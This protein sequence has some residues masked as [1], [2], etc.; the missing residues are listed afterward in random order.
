[1]NYNM[2]EWMK[3]VQAIQDKWK[4]FSHIYDN[5]V[6]SNLRFLDS[7]IGDSLAKFQNQL[8]VFKRMDLS[9]KFEVPLSENLELFKDIDFEQIDKNYKENYYH[10]LC[11]L[12]ELEQ[13][14]Y[15]HSRSLKEGL[16]FDANDVLSEQYISTITQALEIH[17]ADTSLI[18]IWRGA[19]MAINS[20]NP[21]KIRHCFVSL[22]TLLEYL[23]NKKLNIT[24]EDVQNFVDPSFDLSKNP[25]GKLKLAAFLTKE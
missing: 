16:T 3:A 1:M 17:L 22:R 8:A 19:L 9:Y 7:S 11:L 12:C 4:P 5:P 2:P 25:G 15:A 18:N 21:D 14:N 6:I 23:I 20:D 13:M 24:P 10:H